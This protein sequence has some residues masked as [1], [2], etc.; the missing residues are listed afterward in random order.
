VYWSWA[1]TC[2]EVNGATLVYLS[3]IY[4]A[5]ILRIEEEKKRRARQI[6]PTGPSLL[7]I[8]TYLTYLTMYLEQAAA[9]AIAQIFAAVV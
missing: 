1:V 5:L 8:Q 9:P 3:V 2:G 4:E 7:D 6:S